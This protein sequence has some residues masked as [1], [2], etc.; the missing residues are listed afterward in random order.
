MLLKE[1][2]KIK[3]I[4][5]VKEKVEEVKEANAQIIALYEN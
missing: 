3:E 2:E 4:G 5:K 1:S